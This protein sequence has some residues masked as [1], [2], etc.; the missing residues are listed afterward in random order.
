[1]SKDYYNIL[2]V[3]KN[4]TQEEI[5]KAFRKKAHEFHPDK[6]GGNEAKFKEINEAY[7]VVGNEEKRQKYDQFGSDFDQQGGFGGGQ[8]WSDFMRYARQGNGNA[9]NFDM[10]D[11]GDI[12]GDIFGFGGRS[13]GRRT[14]RGNDIEMDLELDFAESVFGMKK[15]IDLYRDNKCSH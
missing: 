9:Q 15:E 1:M 2:G 14:S 11:L 12:F 5:K 7:Q 10:G 13:S 6:P 3:E 4:A 8:D